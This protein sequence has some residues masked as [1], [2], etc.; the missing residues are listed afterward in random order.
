MIEFFKRYI[1]PTSASRAKLSVHMVAQ[2][3]PKEAAGNITP[4]EQTE[5]VINVIGK[6]LTMMGI[7]VDIEKLSARLEIVDIPG[8]DQRSIVE[9]IS[10]YLAEDVQAPPDQTESVLTQGEELLGTILP[11]LGIEVQ[12]KPDEGAEDMPEAP[13]LAPTVL[14]DNVHDFKASLS[15]TAGARPVEDIAR[16]EELEP[17]L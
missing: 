11:S 14:I 13:K 9:A 15:L 16:Y 17:K 6:Y 7:D 1:D 10:D 12:Q 4:E 8:G 5:K 3:S 2:S